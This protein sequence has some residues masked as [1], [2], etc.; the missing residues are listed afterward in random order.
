MIAVNTISMIPNIKNAPCRFHAP[1]TSPVTGKKKTMAID[2]HILSRELIGAR[3]S[4]GIN[5][6]K[7]ADAIG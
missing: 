6:F 3:C 2:K 4:E 7:A 5:S 1:A